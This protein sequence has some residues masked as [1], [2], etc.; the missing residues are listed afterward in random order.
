MRSN[1]HPK[2]SCETSV[3]DNASLVALKKK[4]RH[5]AAETSALGKNE[6]GLVARMR[7]FR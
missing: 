2:E 5:K 1:F 7:I 4:R 6:S 3:D